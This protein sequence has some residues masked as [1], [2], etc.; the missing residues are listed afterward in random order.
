M[1]LARRASS[2]V[3]TA[4]C[5][6]WEPSLHWAGPPTF[7]NQFRSTTRKQLSSCGM[8]EEFSSKWLVLDPWIVPSRKGDPS[9]WPEFDTRPTTNLEFVH[10]CDLMPLAKFLPWACY[11]QFRLYCRH[12]CFTG[13]NQYH[14]VCVHRYPK[15]KYRVFTTFWSILHTCNCHFRLKTVYCFSQ[16]GAWEPLYLRS[17]RSTAWPTLQGMENVTKFNKAK[18]TSGCGIG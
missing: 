14:C 13:Y 6:R 5:S 3:W 8:R 17:A 18:H 12:E 9:V 11:W 15:C 7:M 1:G 4:A 16:S 2:C 10:E